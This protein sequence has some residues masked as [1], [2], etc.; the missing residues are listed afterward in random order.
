MPLCL[1]DQR[2]RPT[3]P[4][5]P[6]L[7]HGH[8]VLVGHESEREDFDAVQVGPCV[9][10]PDGRGQAAHDRPDDRSVVI[11]PALRALVAGGT[12]HALGA[13]QGRIVEDQLPQVLLEPER[14]IRADLGGGVRTG[15]P[16][17]ARNRS[18]RRTRCAA[19]ASAAAGGKQHQCCSTH[20]NPAGARRDTS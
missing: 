2:I 19:S 9:S 3:V 7:G 8:A 12:G 16:S 5:Q 17:G 1:H 11:G 20:E 10:Q 6:A 4:E 14:R 13:G 15:R 18:G